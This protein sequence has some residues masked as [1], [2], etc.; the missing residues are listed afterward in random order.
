ML[1]GPVPVGD[2]VDVGKED[3]YYNTPSHLDNSHRQVRYLLVK[4]N[5]F[6]VCGGGGL[7]GVSGS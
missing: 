7:K 1:P 5:S 2:S 6:V 3:H 4:V